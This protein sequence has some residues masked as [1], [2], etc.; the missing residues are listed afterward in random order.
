MNAS[1][2]AKPL[3]APLLPTRPGSAPV[4]PVCAPTQGSTSHGPSLGLAKKMFVFHDCPL[5]STCMC[6]QLCVHS[7]IQP[8]RHSQGAGAV[9]ISVLQWR[10]PRPKFTRYK[11]RTPIH[12]TPGSR[13]LAPKLPS[14]RS[15]TWCPLFAGDTNEVCVRKPKSHP[16]A[17][18]MGIPRL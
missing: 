14:L 15:T 7:L 1:L 13:P 3:C 2:T 12:L 4:L 17:L 10:K 6:F 8:S 16:L 9:T 5:L 11:I 18:Q